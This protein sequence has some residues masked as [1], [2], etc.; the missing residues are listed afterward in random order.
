M[1][2]NGRKGRKLSLEELEHVYRVVGI[3]KRRSSL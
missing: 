1:P 2:P 3:I